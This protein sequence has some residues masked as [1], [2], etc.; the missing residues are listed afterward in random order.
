MLT[1]TLI[2]FLSCL[3]IIYQHLVYQNIDPEKSPQ[4]FKQIFISCPNPKTN[5]SIQHLGFCQ[6]IY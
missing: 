2:S 3:K 4:E 6:Y 5:S 1:N